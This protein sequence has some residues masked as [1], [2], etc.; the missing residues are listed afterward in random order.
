MY[1]GDTARWVEGCQ[2][3]ADSPIEQR[4]KILHKFISCAWGPSTLHLTSFNIGF[5]DFLKG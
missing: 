5:A 1:F 2:S 4:S 3:I